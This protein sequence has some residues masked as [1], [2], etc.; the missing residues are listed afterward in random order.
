VLDHFQ[1]GG[2]FFFERGEQTLSPVFLP[3][4]VAEQNEDGWARATAEMAA[5][6][7]EYGDDWDAVKKRFPF[8]KVSG[9]K[10]LKAQRNMLRIE[11]RESELTQ[12]I[13][14]YGLVHDAFYHGDRGDVFGPWANKV[15][16]HRWG[17]E[18]GVWALKVIDFSLL[19]GLPVFE[20]GSRNYDL[21]YED[22]LNLSFLDW[23]QQGLARVV[24]TVSI[25]R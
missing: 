7:D 24:P 2:R 9:E 4:P 3:V 14:G 18:P 6:I 12:I 23:L 1:G 25:P 16:Y 15:K 11:A 21:A 19:G 8:A 13:T 17:S 5:F 22:Y 10:V 20:P